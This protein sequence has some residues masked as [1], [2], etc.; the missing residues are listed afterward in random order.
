M[1]QFMV[2]KSLAPAGTNP[3]GASSKKISLVMFY[4]G[5]KKTFT[6]VYQRTPDI[7]ISEVS[8]C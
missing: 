1:I 3:P 6:T 4:E 7:A 2:E 5:L 8:E